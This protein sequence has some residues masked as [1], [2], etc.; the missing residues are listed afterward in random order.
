MKVITA[1]EVQN[2]GKKF[3]V[4]LGGSIE[5]GKARDWQQELISEFSEKDIVALNPRR[6][7]WSDLD[8]K[9]LKTQ[10][11]WELNGIDNVDVVFFFIQAD[12]QSVIS[13]LEIGYC[14]GAKKDIIVVC[15][16]GYFRKT[17]VVETVQRFST[18][19]VYDTIE[20]GIDEL[21]R[22]VKNGSK[23]KGST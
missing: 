22:R 3:S 14:L 6:K 4:F 8:Q 12:T 21:K 13:L 19:W 15:E 5:Q 17:N 16:D 1:P 20:D 18:E 11:H 9:N 2:V 7:V 23:D 10:I